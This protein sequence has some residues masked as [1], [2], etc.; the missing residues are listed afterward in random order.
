MARGLGLI[1]LKRRAAS[2]LPHWTS[3][4]PLVAALAACRTHVV[5]A[6]AF[7]ALLNLLYLAPTL[8]M[9][10]VYD[11]VVPARAGLTLLFL[12]LVLAF[13]IATLAAL[14]AVR[15]RL[16]VRASMRLDRLLA[17]TI[18]QA[19]LARP[20]EGGEVASRQ[21]MRNFDTLRQ[22]LTSG[23]LLSLFDAP[24]ILIYLLVCFLLN[25]LLGLVAL[26]GGALLLA[27]T[28]RNERATKTRLQRATE[29][30]NYAYVSQEQSVGAADVV[31][32]LGMQRAMVARHLAERALAGRLQVEASFA[33]GGYMAA[34]RFVRLFL[35]SLA[36]GVGAGLAIN[37]KLSAGA[38]FAASFLVSRGLAPLES[39]LGAWKGLG[40]A[41][42]AWRSLSALLNHPPPR[43]H[44]NLPPP[45]GDLEVDRLVVG[46]PHGEG[47]I[48]QGLS[49]KLAAGEVVAV[50]GPSG[51]GKSTLLRALAGAGGAY[52]GAIRFDG[53]EL[54][55]YDPERLAQR[56][57]YL[58]QD[59]VLFSGTIKQ[60]IARFSSFLAEDPDQVDERVIAAA[61]ACGMHDMILRLAD[62]YD[63][64]L[65]FAGK[66]LS[67]GQAQGV[68]LARAL[69]GEPQVLM[70]DEPN[71]HLDSDGEARLIQTLTEQK[72]RGV[73][74]LIAAH[75]SGV[76][77]VVDRLMVLREGRID[78]FGPRDMVLARLSASNVAQHP[79]PV[80]K[81]GGS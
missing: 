39:M 56:I 33:T 67:A 74:A 30:A 48:L 53:A 16:F 32:A 7:S 6:A 61:K 44:T 47:A 26:V 11:R 75:R 10:Q 23:A 2:A 78:L 64:V 42:L 54:K 31:R 12:T 72:L 1:D 45:R 50:V 70:L 63:T 49:F 69:F 20:R 3:D 24:W 18:L 73:S 37:G 19:A 25:P 38:I 66:G 5:G 58:P 28:W 35:Q 77:A 65:G 29:A 40:Q 13:A 51:A 55:D 27:V 21:A 8:Y 60:N 71:A 80:A 68:A 43:V 9:L 17:G 36:L 76:L 22:T 52:G 46:K 62:G 57:G 81:T 59:T 14:D 4:Q 41:Q 34:T 79:S 15:S